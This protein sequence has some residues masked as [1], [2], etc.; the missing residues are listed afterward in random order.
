MKR[1]IRRDE[2]VSH[3]DSVGPVII[4]SLHK[5]VR[6][7]VGH[8]FGRQSLIILSPAE[9]LKISDALKKIAFEVI[10]KNLGRRS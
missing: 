3:R 6:M 2:Y 10:D 1:T 5:R 4:E 9:A 7:I 8:G